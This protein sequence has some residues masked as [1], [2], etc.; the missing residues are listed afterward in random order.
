M[1]C[2]ISCDPM[3]LIEW[4]PNPSVNLHIPRFSHQQHHHAS[5][6]QHRPQNPCNDYWL[7]SPL[8]YPC[9]HYY[10]L[11]LPCIPTYLAPVS[12]S[13]HWTSTHCGQQNLWYPT[14]GIK[15][16]WLFQNSFPPTQPHTQGWHPDLSKNIMIK[17]LW[18]SQSPSSNHALFFRTSTILIHPS[19]FFAFL[20]LQWDKSPITKPYKPTSS[21]PKHFPR[22]SPSPSFA[23]LHP[24]PTNPS[25][26]SSQ[27]MMSG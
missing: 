11:L 13:R 14:S 17:L 24:S 27:R 9:R 5:T 15:C 25:N 8:P 2:S 12:T 26:I 21:H 3:Y 6:Y 16:L 20:L 18:T 22:P 10:L 7:S 23:P 4:T 1:V 19:L